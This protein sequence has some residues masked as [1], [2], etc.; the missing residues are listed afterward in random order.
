MFHGMG[1]RSHTD[2]TAHF[3]FGHRRMPAIQT[4]IQEISTLRPSLLPRA[5]ALATVALPTMQALRLRNADLYT[6]R[7][8]IIDLFLNK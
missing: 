3:L 6:V 7:K 4:A 5:G 1:G 2:G 8:K